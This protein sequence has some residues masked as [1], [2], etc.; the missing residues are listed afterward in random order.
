MAYSE[1]LKDDVKRRLQSKQKVKEISEELGISISAIY[2][3][4]KDWD[5]EIRQ[6]GS[7][8]EQENEKEESNEQEI[9]RKSESEKQ[10][11]DPKSE[12][13]VIEKEVG[14]IQYGTEIGKSLS[15]Q[16]GESERSIFI[17][18]IKVS[19][20]K[21]KETEQKSKR[22]EANY[23]NEIINYLTQKRQDIYLKMQAQNWQIQS[24]GIA[25]WDK[26]EALIERVKEN[27]DNNEYLN[28][29]HEKIKI[30]KAKERGE[31]RE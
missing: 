2:N 29:L 18:S 6:K 10:K 28:A 31:G 21:P 26:M 20:A 22:K 12:R 7:T 30:L 9:K 13:P 1:E 23:F 17:R 3:W 5:G 27:K 4:K 25:Q 15:T 8:Q 11:R 24:E 19:P 16:E 14:K